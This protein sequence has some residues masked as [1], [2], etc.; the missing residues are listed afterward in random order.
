M[1]RRATSRRYRVVARP[2]T[3]AR[4]IRAAAAVVA[5]LILGGLAAA[6]A[7]HA[8]SAF[9]LA[10][11]SRPAA[12]S[13]EG[14]SVGGAVEP[15]LSLAQAAVDAVPGSAGEKAEALKARFPCVADVSVRR[16][17]GEKRATL[18]PVLRRSVAPVL[19]RGRAAGYLGDDGAVFEA[20]AGVFS[21]SGPAVDVAGAEAKELQV[22]AREWPAL[23][24]AGA[25]PAPLLV[26]SYRS[27]E[28]G[29]EARL[30]D[31]TSVRWG[32]LDWTK[33]KLARLSEAM[34]DARAKEPGALAA[35]LRYFADGK[36]LLKPVSL[37]PLGQI[38]AA[39]PRGGSR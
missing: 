6:S 36:V 5:V 26:L 27:V 22:L 24:E 31:G 39:G 3:R 17:W 8:A 20:P 34:I 14:V 32:H 30:E 38:A 25:L 9:R 16:P 35:D 13:T 2:Q 33:E 11:L 10:R 28:D 7:R 29:W 21:F 37:K 19:R 18:T 15:F 1:S 23:S 12:S 4:R